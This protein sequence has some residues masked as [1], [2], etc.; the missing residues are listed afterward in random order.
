MCKCLDNSANARQAL[1]TLATH[2]TVTAALFGSPVERSEL[3]DQAAPHVQVLDEAKTIVE[4]TKERLH[5]ENAKKY[6][7]HIA[8]KATERH[9]AAVSEKKHRA[10]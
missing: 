5:R 4:D 8:A 2:E 9:L 10:A 6:T 7:A 3:R 1:A